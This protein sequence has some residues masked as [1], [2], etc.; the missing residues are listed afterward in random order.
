MIL[1]ASQRAGGQQ[2]A[3]HLLRADENEHVELH[4]LRGFVA[5]DLHGAFREAQAVSKGTK[6]R[7]YLFSLSLNPPGEANVSEREFRRAIQQIESRL[8]L[9]GQPR[10]IVFHEKEGRRHAHCVWSRIDAETMTAIN[11]PHFKRKLR[12]T[13]RELFLEHGWRMPEGLVDRQ[14]RDP[15]N[16]TREEWQQAKRAKV[17]PRVVKETLREC[18][19]ISDTKASFENALQSQGYWLA[20]G[21]RRGFVAVDFRGEI[22]SLTR[23]T[24]LKGKEI[25]ARLGEPSKLPTVEETKAQI[26]ARMTGR[27]RGYVRDAEAAFERKTDG[28]K[29][30]K[31]ALVREQR[32]ERQKLAADQKRRWTRETNERASRIRKGL[33]GLWDW[34][35]GKYHK[36]KRLNERETVAAL[37]RDRNERDAL[38]KR[39][40]EKRRALQRDILAARKELNNERRQLQADIARYVSGRDVPNLDQVKD[41]SN[42]PQRPD[43]PRRRIRLRDRDRDRDLER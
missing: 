41:R 6:C 10:A 37:R 3:K 30:R 4:E 2:L 9:I 8:D 15:L 40:L 24:G 25:A 1:K 14:A 28:L 38:I 42:T 33:P 12:D 21:D 13:S 29:E 22:Y 35:T 11:L 16:F 36:A 34:L 7:Q 32:R 17:D 23:S 43:R 20:Q 5:D 31:E 18:W 39:Q 19:A 27:L 26:A